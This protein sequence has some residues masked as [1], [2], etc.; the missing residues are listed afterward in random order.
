M[1]IIIGTAIIAVLAA[2]AYRMQKKVKLMEQA[3]QQQQQMLDEKARKRRSVNKSIQVLAQG[4]KDDQLTKT[5]G[6]IRISVLLE[7]LSIDDS[8]REEYSA[9]FQLA[10]ATAHIPILEQ[11]QKLS[12][13]EK[14]RYDSERVNFMVILS[15]MRHR[16]FRQKF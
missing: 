12:T 2:V 6:A 1:L 13:K 16:E 14:L 8:V 5:E 11:W 9:F 10:E 7:S 15:S 4:I 3:K